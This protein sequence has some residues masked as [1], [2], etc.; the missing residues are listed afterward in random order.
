MYHNNILIILHE[1][2]V[3]KRFIDIIILYLIIV[4]IVIICY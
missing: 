1:D 4:Q 3:S 2:S